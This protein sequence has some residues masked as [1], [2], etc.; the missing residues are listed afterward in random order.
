MHPLSKLSQHRRSF[1]RS[2]FVC[3]L[4]LIACQPSIPPVGEP[5]RILFIGNSYTIQNDLPDMLARLLQAGGYEPA[6]KMIAHGGWTLADHARSDETVD[7]IIGGRWDYVLLQEQS[8]LP[9]LAGRRE[10]EM[11][12][13]V[14]A[15]DEMIRKGGAQTVL[16]MTWGRRDGLPAENFPDYDSMQTTLAT[17]TTEIADELGAIVAPVGLAWQRTLALQPEYDLWDADG[18]HPSATG[19]Y[20]AAAVLYAT[21]LQRSPEEASYK[22]VLWAGRA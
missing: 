8:V 2:L 4:V 11:Y 17:G 14:R 1:L 9:A 5:L 6:V 15:L 20:L 3:A 12:P 22:G 16:I 13:A 10:K 21:L 18:S 7:A 19:S